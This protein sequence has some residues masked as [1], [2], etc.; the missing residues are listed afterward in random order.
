VKRLYELCSSPVADFVVRGERWQKPQRQ[1]EHHLRRN[2]VALG[3]CWQTQYGLSC[4]Q[5]AARLSLRPR[6]LRQWQADDSAA[7]KRRHALGRPVLRSPR[8]ER[9]AVL[10]L[11][12]E[13]GLATGVPTLCDCF[14]AMPRAELADLLHRARRL[15]Q[16]RYRVCQQALSWT[17]PGAVWAMDFT[18]ADAPIDGLYRYLLAVRDL[19]SGLQLLTLPLARATSEEAVP[20]LARLFDRHGAPLVLK[21]DNGSPFCAPL[22]RELL[23]QHQVRMLFSPPS[24]PRYNGAIEA[25]IGSL[26]TRIEHHAAHHGR[27]GQWTWDDAVWAQ[28]AANA[29]ARPHGLYGPTP[30]QAWQARRRITR[31]ERLLLQ[32]SIARHRGEVIAQDGWPSVGPLP[33]MEERAVDR[34]AIQRALVEHGYL[35]FKRRRLPLPIEKQKTAIIM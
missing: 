18:E 17:R 23:Y 25:G 26:K 21:T 8:Q 27:P 4:P 35:L 30:D 14:P 10:E 33:A 7:S 32:T 31:E 28:S 19:A 3:T 29:T 5:I 16:R 11:L 22:T 34:Q 1:R 6:T 15:C 2:I 9:R 24:W 13:L 12:V 20:V